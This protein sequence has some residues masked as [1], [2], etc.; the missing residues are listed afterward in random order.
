[1]MILLAYDVD[2]KTPCGRRRLHETARL[3]ESMGTRVQRSLFEMQL[4]PEQLAELKSH[5]TK[6][7]DPETDSIRIYHLS[8]RARERTETLGR[9]QLTPYD[10]LLAV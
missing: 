3:C 5:L 4:D 6:L 9:A 7:I 10:G 2:T 1:M 8:G